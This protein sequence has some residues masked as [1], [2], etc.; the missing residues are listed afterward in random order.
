MSILSDWESRLRVLA[1]ETETLLAGQRADHAE[2]LRKLADDI[3]NT[4]DSMRVAINLAREADEW[5]ARRTKV[6]R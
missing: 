2:K 6:N 4:P 1:R 5:P 3:R